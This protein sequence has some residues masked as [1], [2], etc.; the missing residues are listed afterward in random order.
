MAAK[1]QDLV[2]DTMA[3]VLA[4]DT[5]PLPPSTL[6]SNQYYAP[7]LGQYLANGLTRGVW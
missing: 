4:G 2:V 3:R 1:S 7:T 5:N 6:P